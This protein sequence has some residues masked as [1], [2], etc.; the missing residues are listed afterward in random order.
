MFVFSLFKFHFLWLAGVL[1]LS[2]SFASGEVSVFF[3]FCYCFFFVLFYLG[4]VI[5]NVSFVK[6]G[7]KFSVSQ[8]V[9]GER[10][11][12]FGV[13]TKGRGTTVLR[14]LVYLCESQGEKCL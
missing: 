6:I 3:C 1:F 4:S 5:F 12:Y 9:S 2:V 14:V 13:G 8:V 11:Q 10:T 7:V